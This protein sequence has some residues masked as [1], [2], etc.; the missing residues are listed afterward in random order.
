MLDCDVS[1]PVRCFTCHVLAFFLGAGAGARAV[2]RDLGGRGG[3]G[4]RYRCQYRSTSGFDWC[5]RASET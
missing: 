3:P 5:C 4:C 2:L 1:V